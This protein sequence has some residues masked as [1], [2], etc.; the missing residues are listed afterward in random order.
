MTFWRWCYTDICVI[1][2]THCNTQQHTATRCNTLQHT[3]THCN[4]LQWRFDV[5]VTLIYVSFL[6]HYCEYYDSRHSF[7]LQCVAVCYEH[8]TA[9]IMTRATSFFPSRSWV[10]SHVTHV[11]YLTHY[12]YY[13]V[14]YDSRHIFIA[15]SHMWRKETSIFGV[16]LWG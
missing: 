9:C 1:P 5:D 15:P 2:N 10:K 8:I 11:S 16:M 6:T 14:Y 12:K 3:A 4:T 13:R 7:V